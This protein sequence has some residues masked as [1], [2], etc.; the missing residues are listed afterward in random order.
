M[1]KLVKFAI[2]FSIVFVA[3]VV[4]PWYIYTYY[5]YPAIITVLGSIWQMSP[6]VQDAM[7]WVILFVVWLLTSI[8]GIIVK[9]KTR[10][11]RR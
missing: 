8:G 7:Y 2:I 9:V 4:L 3:I 11:K 1:N 5:I 10:K 6:A